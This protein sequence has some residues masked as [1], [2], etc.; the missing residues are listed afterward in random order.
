M[1]SKRYNITYYTSHVM[2]DSRADSLHVNTF[3]E[4][5]PKLATEVTQ[6]IKKC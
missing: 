4:N 3:D 2:K 6:R 1:T 5:R